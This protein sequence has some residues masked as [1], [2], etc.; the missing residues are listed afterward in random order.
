MPEPL[1]GARGRAL[2]SN[3]HRRYR[4]DRYVSQ[5]AIR[6]VNISKLYFYGARTRGRSPWGKTPRV[7]DSFGGSFVAEAS[8]VAG[9]SVP[10]PL[11]PGPPVRLD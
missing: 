11:P 9:F 6:I 4:I 7:A 5:L 8:Y 1:R 10:L 2:T 3:R